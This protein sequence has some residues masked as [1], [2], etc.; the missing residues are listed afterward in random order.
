MDRGLITLK[1]E[2]FFAKKT[3]ESTFS[4]VRESDPTAQKYM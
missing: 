2:G 3:R 1:F 4:T